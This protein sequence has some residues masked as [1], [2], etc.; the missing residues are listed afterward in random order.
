MKKIIFLY[1]TFF[2]FFMIQV[3]ENS[4]F[5]TRVYMHWEIRLKLNSNKKAKHYI[6]KTK[7]NE[8]TDNLTVVVPPVFEVSAFKLILKQVCANNFL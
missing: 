8:N 2:T 4:E 1:K 6:S 5:L 7:N 3:L